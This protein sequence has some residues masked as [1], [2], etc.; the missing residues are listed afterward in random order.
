[1]L[2]NLK[3][4]AV[5]CT[6]TLLPA[7]ENVKVIGEGGGSEGRVYIWSFARPFT[8]YRSSMIS[9]NEIPTPQR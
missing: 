6:S 1:M 3:E 4:G 2:A 8:H 7:Q 5:P 9:G